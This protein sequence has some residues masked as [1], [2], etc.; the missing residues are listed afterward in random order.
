MSMNWIRRFL[1]NLL[2]GSWM[3]LW[4]YNPDELACVTEINAF[5]KI[6]QT[7]LTSIRTRKGAQIKL[8]VI[9]ATSRSQGN[10]PHIERHHAQRP[11]EVSVVNFCH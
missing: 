8:E 1:Y 7:T 6:A 5:V 4:E 11:N 10:T 3:D 9:I 2:T